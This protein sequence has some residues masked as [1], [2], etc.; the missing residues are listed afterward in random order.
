MT[1]ATMRNVTT[2][3]DHLSALVILVI[4]ETAKSVQV[5]AASGSKQKF[6][7][8]LNSN[9][10]EIGMGVQ[11]WPFVF[12]IHFRGCP[13]LNENELLKQNIPSITEI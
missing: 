7:L 10:F 8:T 4:L 13:R 9:Q 11:T 2:H 5:I 6:G 1:A 3:K 12:L